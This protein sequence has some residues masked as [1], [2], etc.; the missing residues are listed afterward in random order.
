MARS[1][2][3]LA[4]GETYINQ[5]VGLKDGNPSIHHT[6]RDLEEIKDRPFSGSFADRQVAIRYVTDGKNDAVMK[7]AWTHLGVSRPGY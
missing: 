5:S 7:P 4:A 6:I 1:L 3:G 2:I